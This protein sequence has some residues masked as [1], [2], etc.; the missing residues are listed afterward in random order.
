MKE[1][2]LHRNLD[3]KSLFR[4][5][6]RQVQNRS[7]SDT[8]IKREILWKVL[9]LIFVTAFFQKDDADNDGIFNASLDFSHFHEEGYQYN[10]LLT[11]C[12]IQIVSDTLRQFSAVLPEKSSTHYEQFQ[13][14]LVQQKQMVDFLFS[15]SQKM[16]EQRGGRERSSE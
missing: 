14:D 2:F 7:K 10:S 8:A 9:E 3:G 5:L 12:V 6:S 16:P 1:F 13:F 4:V 11:K 15:N